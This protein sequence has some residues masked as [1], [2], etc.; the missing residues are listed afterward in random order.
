V[1]F[2]ILRQKNNNYSL[3]FYL[4]IA[5]HCALWVLL[6]LLLR[7]NLHLDTLEA[8]SWGQ[9]WQLGY[10]KHPPL[11]AWLIE[12]AIIILGKKIYVCYLA[13][14][15][16]VI[17]S[18][19][20][21]WRLAKLFLPLPQ[22]LMSVMLLEGIYYYNFTSI[23]YNTNVLMLAIWAWSILYSWK[24]C[25][26][27]YS[28]HWI[29]LGIL[30]GL[31]VIDKYYAAILCVAIFLTIIYESDFR[32]NLKTFK[33]YLAPIFFLIITIPHLIWLVKNDYPTFSYIADRASSDNK[34][35]NHLFYPLS[36]LL[37]QIL[38]NLGALIIFFT[39]FWRKIKKP[40]IFGDSKSIFLIFMI[41]LP[42]ILTILPSLLTGSKMKDMWGTS[43]WG[44]SGI[45]LF[46][47]LRP[48]INQQL[49][50]RF[51]KIF[52]VVNALI[53]SI[54]SLSI[55]LAKYDKRDS[56][57]GKLAAIEVNKEW[58][59]YN[60]VPLKIVAGDIW[61]SSNISF[62]S[63]QNISV[64]IDMDEKISPWISY[65]QLEENGGVILWDIKTDGLGLPSKYKNK[66]KSNMVIDSILTIKSGSKRYKDQPNFELGVE[67]IMPK[68][69]K[70]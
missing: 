37:T 45:C 65:Q 35:Y 38:S 19:I 62:F 20:A 52:L 61:L 70:H 50:K 43:L 46:Y 5:L 11:S 41:F 40:H 44:L 4:F 3:Y 57:N 18:L 49:I 36:F 9:E 69:Y 21:I 54:Y 6:P 10:H 25:N 66:I 32:K 48:E 30:L 59:K 31:G 55:L 56:F 64:F 39:T 63:D 23:E 58:L 67:I 17:L 7:S 60:N 27:N 22:A 12:L 1:E 53:I 2:N 8:I 24:A 28:R 29:K 68:N 14:Q 16:C 13:S 15:I 34:F 26:S 33:P 47:F 51:F 42:V